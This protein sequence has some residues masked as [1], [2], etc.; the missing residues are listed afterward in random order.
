M[1][2]LGNPN[3]FKTF[4]GKYQVPDANNT[5]HT[6]MLSCTN[7]VIFLDNYTANSNRLLCTLPT[8]LRPN[9]NIII[10]CRYN[11]G[12]GYITINSNGQVQASTASREFYMRGL[13][14]N[15][16]SNFYA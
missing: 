15:I 7:D 4:K 3:F 14:F 11:S 5:N 9:A 2:E 1:A 8:D 12:N 16:S 6:V 10:Y 13:S